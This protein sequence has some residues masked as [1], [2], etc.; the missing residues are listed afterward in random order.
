MQKDKF[1]Q[2]QGRT[3]P[4]GE[5]IRATYPLQQRKDVSE[6]FLYSCVANNSYFIFRSTAIVSSKSGMVVDPAGD[7]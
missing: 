5:T 3:Q 1:D 2:R 6:L 7:G 4:R